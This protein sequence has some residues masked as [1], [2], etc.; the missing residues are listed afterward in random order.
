MSQDP[1]LLDI[2]SRLGHLEGQSNLILQ[3][4]IRA[5]Q[6]R[7]ETYKLHEENKASIAAVKYTVDG[8]AKDLQAMK[9]EV[10]EM[11]AFKV[12]LAVAAMFVSAVLTGAINLVVLGFSNI[13]QIKTILRDFF[14]R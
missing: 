4:Q 11:K 3:E 2:A 13:G 12:K 5:S 8:V 10:D 7:S 9:P 1:I 6:S 14:L